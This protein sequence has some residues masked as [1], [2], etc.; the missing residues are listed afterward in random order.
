MAN[1]ER[2]PLI[3]QHSAKDERFQ[4]CWKHTADVECRFGAVRDALTE[5]QQERLDEY[6]AAR[7]ELALAMAYAAYELGR[8]YN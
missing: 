3:L 6:L 2:L 8:K 5:E 7:E 1:D 4:K